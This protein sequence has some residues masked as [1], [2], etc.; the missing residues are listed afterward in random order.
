MREI[1][2][3]G[4]MSGER[5]RSDAHRAQATAP[6]LDS[7]DPVG[8]VGAIGKGAELLAEEDSADM[9]EAALELLAMSAEQASRRLRFS[10]LVFGTIKWGDEPMDEGGA[11]GLAAGMLEGGRV[12][13]DWP[14]GCPTGLTQGRG[15]ALLNLM[16]V[17]AECL[18]SGGTVRLGEGRGG[19]DVHA[20]GP[21]ARL[22]E[23]LR[24]GLGD[25]IATRDLESRAVG[26]ASA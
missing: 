14:A 23:G 16:L 6:L 11:R 8:P 17:A 26:P 4:L 15:R 24:D 2:T 1:R 20:E 19:V 13:L 25:S 7:T 12:R 3:S 18:P 22:E 5:K 10:R 9:R 21:G